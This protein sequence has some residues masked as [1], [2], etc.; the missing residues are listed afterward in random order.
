MLNVG[1]IGLGFMGLTHLKIPT[2]HPRAK[3]V[4]V[5]DSVKK[6]LERDLSGN[7][8]NILGPGEKFDFTGIKT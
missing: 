6:R 3:L 8:G 7:Q 5:A 1:I 2:E 4:A